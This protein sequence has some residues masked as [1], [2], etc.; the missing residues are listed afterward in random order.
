MPM[1][2]VSLQ[3]KIPGVSLSPAEARLCPPCG[4]GLAAGRFGCCLWLLSSI[5]SRV[6][7]REGTETHVRLLWSGREVLVSRKLSTLALCRAADRVHSPGETQWWHF[8]KGPEVCA[9]SPGCGMHGLA[10]Q[11]AVGV[12]TPPP[13]PLLS[14]PYKASPSSRSHLYSF[15]VAVCPNLWPFSEREG[16]GWNRQAQVYICGA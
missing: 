14:V 16:S 7:L 10:L 2:Q 9:V 4:A 6:R 15:G 13:G 3:K 8:W 5:P 1:T 11:G 12:G